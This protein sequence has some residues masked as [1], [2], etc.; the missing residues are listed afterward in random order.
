MRPRSAKLTGRP[1]WRAFIAAPALA[2]TRSPCRQA[3]G[4]R[5]P[6]RSR[7]PCR[8]RSRAPAAARSARRRIDRSLVLLSPY[9]LAEKAVAG[10]GRLTDQL[11]GA[12]RHGER[13]LTPREAAI[14]Q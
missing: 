1:R 14:A 3:V 10:C 12:A 9:V 11:P 7:A 13:W 2:T 6:G 5:R 4:R 8:W